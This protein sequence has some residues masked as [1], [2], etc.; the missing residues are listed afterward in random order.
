MH[1]VAF[2]PARGKSKAIPRKNLALLNGKPLIQYTIE[3]ARESKY[4][5]EIFISSDDEEIIGFCRSLGMEVPYVR[6][7][8]LA[9]DDTPMID[10]VLDA[11]RWRRE[12]G[13]PVRENILLL[14]PTSPLR[15]SGHINEAIE[16][17]RRERAQSLISVNEMVEHPYDCVR[18]MKGGWEFVALPAKRVFRRQ[19]YQDTFYYINGAIY[20][21][22][23]SFAE[24][25]KSFFLESETSLYVMP[26]EYGVDIDSERDLMRA[27]CFLKS[28][29]RL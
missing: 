7:A 26:P 6:P 8:Q 17:F 16:Q 2:I 4:V 19:D 13:L 12:N 22:K 3:A 11:F 10:V 14:Q 25:Q 28:L 21:V 15:H 1:I 23:M 20:L 29:K 5:D 24:K 27:E 18:I 9:A